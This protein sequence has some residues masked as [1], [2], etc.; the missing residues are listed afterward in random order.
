MTIQKQSI[1]GMYNPTSTPANF[2]EI[3]SPKWMG[4]QGEES[5]G[6]G[7]FRARKFTFMHV[8]ITYKNA[9]GDKPFPGCYKVTR[10]EI[11]NSPKQEKVKGNV[12]LKLLKISDLE[13]ISLTEANKV[14]TL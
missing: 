6:I 3:K 7:E 11:L 5:I 4:R 2:Y 1:R 12:V 8:H 10:E 13:D 14:C 9:H